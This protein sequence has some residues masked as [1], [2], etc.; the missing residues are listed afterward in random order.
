MSFPIQDLPAGEFPPLLREIPQ[1]P[2]QLNYRG[3]LPDPELKLLAVVGSRKYTSYGKQV[4]AHLINGLRGYPIGI[5]SGMAL[6]IDSLAH[7][8]ALS[9]Q[10]YT[11]AVPGG[12]LDDSVLYPANHR[13]LAAQILDARGGL[14]SEFDPLQKA[15]QW[16]FPAR[17][18]I[19]CGLCPA[20]LLIEAGKQSGT[21][22]TARLATD[23]NRDVLIVP[24]SIF[25]ANSAG[26]HQFLK[27]GATPVTAAADILEVLGIEAE[28]AARPEAALPSNLSLPEQNILAALHEPTDRDS[29]IRA[30]GVSAPEA[31]I[32]LMQMEMNDLIAADQNIYRRKL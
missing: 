15:A 17:N 10:L 23:Y 20:T 31:N 25:S 22:I 9:N 24:G 18:R 19:V 4:V 16:T 28:A 2:T 1:P 21:L 14:L 26:T 13:R 6:G 5:V 8:A 29:L 3:R 32:L 30:S 7:E 27:L 11:L 12:G